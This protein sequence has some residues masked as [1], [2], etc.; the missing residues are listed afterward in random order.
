MKKQIPLITSAILC[1]AILCGCHDKDD[2]NVEFNNPPTEMIDEVGK[3][4]QDA[5]H[6]ETLPEK[7]TVIL[8][9]DEKSDKAEWIKDDIN[10]NLYKGYS[11]KTTT[12]HNTTNNLEEYVTFT[13]SD[14]FWPGALIQGK[15]LT[16]GIPDGIP[17]YSKRKKGCIYLS[18]TENKEDMDNWYV[19]TQMSSVRTDLAIEEL[20]EKHVSPSPARTEFTIEPVT[21]P[22]EMTLKLGLNLKLWTPIIRQKFG[23]WDKNK[24][25]VAVKLDR[26]YFSI[27]Y[28]PAEPGYKGVFTEKITTEDLKD[29]T[30]PG[31]PICYVSSV[32]YGESYIMLYESNVSRQSLELA[33][34]AAFTGNKVVGGIDR[35]QT[36]NEAKC[37]MVQIGGDPDAGLETVFGNYE[38]LHNFVT[39]GA[40]VSSHNIGVPISYMLSHLLDNSTVRLSNTL[41][42]NVTTPNFLPQKQKNDVMI[43]IFNAY[44][45]APQSKRKISNYSVITLKAVNISEIDSIGNINN[46][47]Y[48]FPK[49]A[50]LSTINTGADFSIYR[51]ILFQKV[52]KQ[53]RIR[54]KAQFYAKNKTYRPGTQEDED[55]FTLMQEFEFDKTN[56]VWKPVQQT[57]RPFER[58]SKHID[59]FGGATMDFTLNYR[60]YCDGITY[61]IPEKN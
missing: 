54:I 50:T 17:I 38:K 58:L 60:F 9:D 28:E 44:M 7:N 39:E 55:E 26:I 2:K 14:F 30:A 35:T 15:S 25:Y 8:L 48:L 13:P 23:N 6:I 59:N 19:D 4:I 41:E 22:E 24:N 45:P 61:P 52:D 57:E 3:L 43:D 40:I 11:Y 20:I 36:F 49:P 47:K 21:S 33:V 12:R 29:D 16:D 56:N 32:S 10:G 42:Y 5:G 34:Q 27:A 1:L 53:S 51:T 31:N 18:L 37:K 46:F